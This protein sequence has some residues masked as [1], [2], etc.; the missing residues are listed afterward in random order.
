MFVMALTMTASSTA[1]A[2]REDAASEIA[3][4]LQDLKKCRY[5]NYEHWDDFDLRFH[6]EM[7]DEYCEE[8]RSRSKN[9]RNTKWVQVLAELL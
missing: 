2:K 3:R 8:K 5:C 6:E 7:H 4:H 1:N 9:A